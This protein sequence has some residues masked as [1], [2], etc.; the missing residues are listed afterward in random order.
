MTAEPGDGE[1]YA[2]VWGDAPHITPRQTYAIC[3]QLN[4]WK[5]LFIGEWLRSPDE[6]L[7]SVPPFDELDL[8]VMMLVG[9]NR[10][11]AEAVGRRCAVVANEI[12]NGVLPCDR[13]GPFIDEILF[14]T[15]ILTAGMWVKDDPSV[16][17]EVP[18]REVA[19][20]ADDDEDVYVIGDDDWGE[21][22]N[23]F[24]DRARWADYDVPLFRGS[25]MLRLLLDERPPLT[26]LDPR[27][28]VDPG[29]VAQLDE[30][31]GSGE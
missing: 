27:I 12:G 9:E 14:G 20:I 11:W 10:A 24:Y 8:R 31:F 4:L 16:V 29:L 23:E 5:D 1:R 2:H 25:P 13:P 28:D 18:A 19:G 17:E 30:M 7:H 15:A 22:E 21:L 3:V 26:W 6:P